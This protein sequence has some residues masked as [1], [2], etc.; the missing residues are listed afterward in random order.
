MT[1]QD[2]IELIQPYIDAQKNLMTRMETLNKDFRRKYQN[3]PIHNIQYRIKK[4]NS[5]E[6]KLERLGVPK[7]A[8]CA[9]EGLK[10]IA[11]IRV[12]CYFVGDIHSMV[13]LLKKQSDLVLIKEA[14]Y[15]ENP[16][17]NGYRSYHLVFGVPVYYADGMEY[18]PV[19]IQ[20]RTMS[21]DFWASM[22][23]RIC[24]KKNDRHRKLLEPE[25]FQY[26]ELLKEIE[27][28]F[29]KYYEQRHVE[30]DSG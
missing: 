12:I 21:M 7:N 10:D 29:E 5:I 19:E 26:A 14:D 24:Y 1:E 28:D 4:K 22:E 8:I 15:I 23:H 30:S 2:Y 17:L 11:G 18:F 27:G 25:F 9:K 3:Y 20:I 13:V 6:D 16:K